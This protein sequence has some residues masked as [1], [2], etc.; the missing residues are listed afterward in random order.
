MPIE[1][2]EPSLKIPLVQITR[3]PREIDFSEVVRGVELAG[4]RFVSPVNVRV[5]YYRSGDDLFFDG[6]LCA[7]AEAICS[8]CLNEYRFNLEKKFDFVLIPDTLPTNKNRKLSRDEMGLSFYQGEEIDF[9]PLVQEQ[10]LLG[11]PLRPLCNEACLGLCPKCGSDRNASQCDCEVS[12][13][14]SRR[15]M[16]S[17]LRIDR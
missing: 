1:L 6:A 12:S 4:I 16:L 9:H 17:S 5:S 14:D 15:A 2:T 10:A 13:T 7:Q 8:R 3:T 11:V